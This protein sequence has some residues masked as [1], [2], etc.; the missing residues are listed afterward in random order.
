[1]REMPS[2]A[3]AERW[4][5]LIPVGGHPSVDMPSHVVEAAAQ[6]ARRAPYAPTLGLPALR[7][8]IADDHGVDPERQVLVTLGGMQGLYLA[9]RAFGRNAVTHA[10]SF[11]FRQIVE[12]A[13]GTCPSP[14][15]GTSSRS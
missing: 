11:F 15:T 4:P 13:G 7:E 10:P 5:R 14:T 12:V 3:L 9:A 1:M 8:A 6:A 2:R